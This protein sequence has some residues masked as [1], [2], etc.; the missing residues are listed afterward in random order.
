V[1]VWFTD[2]QYAGIDMAILGDRQFKSAPREL[3]PGS[4]IRNGWPANHAK[5]R[6]ML[7]TP[8]ELDAKGADL[9][10]RR[11]EAFLKTWAEHKPANAKWRLVFSATPLMALQ[12]IPEDAFTDDVVPGLKR[13][14]P[15]EYPA[16]DIPKLDYDSNGWPQSKRDLAVDLITR[17]GA[18]H[19]TGDQ[20][21]GSTG[22][23]GVAAFNDSAWWI[24]S[25]AIAN[26]WPRRWFPKDGGNKRRKGAPK[27]TGEFEEGFGNKITVHA[28]ANPYDTDREPARLYDKAVGY[29]ILTLHRKD[30]RITLAN[31]PY[32][33]APGNAAPNRQPYPGWPITIN[34]ST[35][36]RVK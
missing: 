6:P 26:L 29:S 33:S 22:Q 18:L 28:V 30:G 9:L 16:N 23:Y 7:K 34:P 15:G 3:L 21:L 1:S 36:Q 17:A 2:W 19:V 20:H 24:S 8:R 10:G 13:M 4:D 5:Q 14:K 31:W 27:F 25:P 35:H 11:Q 12:T 32:Q